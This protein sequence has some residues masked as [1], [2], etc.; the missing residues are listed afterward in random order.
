MEKKK[1]KYKKIFILFF[2]NTQDILQQIAANETIDY[3]ASE[4][5][6]AYTVENLFS[7]TQYSFQI[8]RTYNG[9]N[10]TSEVLEFTTLPIPTITYLFVEKKM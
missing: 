1:D 3:P 4:S 7:S 5:G 8:T 2:K 9:V 6:S 10:Y